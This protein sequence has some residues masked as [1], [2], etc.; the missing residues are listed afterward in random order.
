MTWTR[1]EF[2][3]KI[4][5]FVASFDQTLDLYRNEQVLLLDAFERER[6]A[7]FAHEEH[8]RSFIAAHTIKR[9]ALS[10]IHPIPPQSWQF[11]T[12]EYGKPIA[13]SDAQLFFNIS[14]CKNA[15]CCAVSR[16]VDVGVDV[17][18]IRQPVPYEILPKLLSTPERR[19]FNSL[20]DPEKARG[21]ISLWTLKEAL[22]KATGRGISQDLTGISFSFEP[23]TVTLQ[24]TS[25]EDPSHWCFYQSSIG[26]DKVL[27]TAWK[28]MY[29]ITVEEKRINIEDVL[30]RPS[31]SR[32][33]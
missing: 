13:K 18:L 31:H 16:L 30:R 23:I 17:E 14:H 32:S 7:N 26:N 10:A 20:Q 9:L 33:L 24:G 4:Y 22:V 11:R 28:S 1:P 2:D 29:N 19:W 25:S 5:L 12:S 27:S 15:V 3:R 21:L 6:A 8:R